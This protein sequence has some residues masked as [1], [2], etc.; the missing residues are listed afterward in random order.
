METRDVIVV[1]AGPAG[2]AAAQRCA[3]GGLNTLLL[4][5]SR[6]PREKLCGG[7]VMGP[8]AHD[9][10]SQEF[11]EVPQS[12]LSAPHYLSGYMFHVPG[13]GSEK[14]ENRTLLAWRSSL[15]Y[16]MNQQAE[17]RGVIIW[18]GARVTGLSRQGSG[19]LVEIEKGKERWKLKTRYLVGA[20]GMGSFTR[21]FL[22]P[23][24]MPKYSYIYQECYR[25][26]L[27][28]DNKYFHWF[29][30]VDKDAISL[31]AHHKGELVVIHVGGLPRQLKER[32]SRARDYL[33]REYNLNLESKTVWRDGCLWSLM[34]GELFS[35]TFRP[36][37]GNALLVGDAGGLVLPVSGEGIGTAIKSGLLAASAIIATAR[38]GEEPDSRYLAA[39]E[40]ILTAFKE[41]YSWTERIQA[42][43]DRGGH[44]LPQV[45]RDAY[46][47]TLRV[48]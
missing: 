48:F 41:M 7:M 12:V 42:E 33:A 29:R 14:L 20:D 39:V 19:F 3:E 6:L 40:D 13:V 35:H 37:Q 18:Q 26:E 11:G 9:L 38:S 25:G 36:A 34:H 10:I 30:P 21:W 22:F 1:G 43:R 5:K 31:A 16:W 15:D 2:T 28:L 8:V 45:Y 4:E 27:D 32:M 47:S 46:Q 17:A 44:A 23:G 24:F